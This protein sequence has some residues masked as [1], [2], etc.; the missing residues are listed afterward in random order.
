M[1][2]EITVLKGE[3]YPLGV[4][5]TGKDGT[6]FA[7]VLPGK[8]EC[9]II[10]YPKRGGVQLR[11]PF[12][13]EGTVGNIRCMR[14]LGIRMQEYEY[15]FY[16]GE[17]VAVDPYARRLSGN[18][19]WG[20]REDCALRC[21]VLEG[22]FDWG[23]DRPLETKMCD[24]IL[25]QLHVRG[26]TRHRSSMVAHKGTFL[27]IVEKIPYL[28][29][30]G[31]TAVELMPAY[32]FLELERPKG[33]SYT[34]AQAAQHYMDPL[35]V[36]EGNVRINYWG[37]KKGYYFAPK[38]SYCGTQDPAAEF[39]SMV[40]ALH[41]NGLEVIMQFYFPPGV[42]QGF[43]LDV[44]RFWVRE[45]HI[46]GAHLM[47]EAMPTVLLAT[48]PLL[49][50][51]KLFYYDFPCQEIYASPDAAD[52]RLACYRDDFLYDM[53]RFLK[54]DEDTL[55]GMLYQLKKNP[56]QT[57]TVNY[58]ANYEGFSLAD[59]VSYERK[60]NEE[61]G[62][63]NRDGNSYNASWNCGIEGKTKKKAV[64][65]LRRKQMRNAVVLLFTAQ[66]TPMLTAGDEFGHSREGNNN[67][68]CQDNEV[69]WLNWKHTESDR[70]FLEF[71]KALIALR[72]AHPIL[73]KPDEM[74]MSDFIACG[75]PELS[76]HGREA[77]RLDI[78]R[79]SR[80]AGVMYCGNYAKID[81]VQ[82]DDFFYIA[83]NMHWEKKKLALPALP[84][85]M[86][87]EKVLDSGTDSVH[88][89]PEEL[90]KSVTVPARSIQILKSVS[91]E[92]KNH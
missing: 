87:W 16:V 11:F 30:L 55:G 54:G 88:L 62:E 52:G 21:A 65:Q 91:Q 84:A 56:R 33:K 83:Y 24:S 90:E 75:Y 77:W 7:A 15:N 26:F 17:E 47:G 40:R 68:Y 1:R 78:D 63:Q 18:E 81:R 39:K 76:Y 44:L 14:L 51:S 28:K 71:V 9:G 72:K 35:P 20:K 38:A 27:G 74:V 69:N 49:A 10:L 42:G 89:E 29:E 37:Y 92:R 43:I 4:T 48:D 46:D 23:K 80:D 66:G 34:M 85:G 2:H 73:H 58:I 64:L 79:I 6:N 59:L 5:V 13:Q 53:R 82:N 45:Y 25:Y 86:H 50:K 41:E 61:N 3:P 57:G 60:H 67:P 12:P 70:G 32:E 36:G 8:E 19:K 22:E 31:V